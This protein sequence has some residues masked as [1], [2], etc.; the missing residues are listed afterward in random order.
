MKSWFK[1]MNP[2]LKNWRW[3]LLLPLIL[4]LTVVVLLPIKSIQKL[5]ELI[6]RFGD[7]LYDNFNYK[8]TWLSKLIEWSEEVE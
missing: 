5:G 8:Q 6:T 2:K 7:A 1:G 4:L 3:W